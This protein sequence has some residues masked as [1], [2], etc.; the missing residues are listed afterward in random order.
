MTR[1]LNLPPED[2]QLSPLT[3]WTREHW[4]AVADHL[5][6]SLRP[7]FST[8]RARV[9]LPGRTSVYGRDSDGLEGF[10]RSFLLAGFRIRGEDG[11]DPHGFMDWYRQGLVEGTDPQS[12]ERWPR[13]DEI[14][15][16]KVEA[17]SIALILDMT[18]QWLWN[19]LTPQEQSNVVAWL[20]TVIGEDYPRNNW[21]WFQIVV[22]TFLAS[23]DGPF[24]ANDVE[25]GLALHESLA[26]EG[27]WY[28]DGPERAFD[29]Y[30]G[31][32]MHFYPLLW[33]DQSGAEDFGSGRFTETWRQ[34]LETYL[35]DYVHLIGAD[36]MPVLQ[37]RSLIYR[38]AAAAPLWM[39]A[40][41]GAT[42]QDLGMIRRG[43]SG[44]VKAFIERGAPGP[45][46]LLTVGLFDEWPD[47]AQSY[48]G[49]GSPYWAAK[50]MLGLALP[51]DHPAWTAVERPLP[52]ETADFL[53]TMDAPGWLVSGTQ[54]DGIVRISNHGT[55]H[56]HEGSRS[57]ESPSYAR[58]GYSTATIPPLTGQALMRPLD[59]SI[60]VVNDDGELTHRTGFHRN[61]L[62]RSDTCISGVTT[63]TPHWVRVSA[64]PG[65]DYGAGREG[66][67]TDAPAMVTASAVRGPW[68]VRMMRFED[69]TRSATV[70]VSGWPLASSLSSVDQVIEENGAIS[71]VVDGLHSRLVPV[72]GVGDY[73]ASVTRDSHVSPLGAYT[74]VPELVVS[75]VG[76]DAV[77]AVAVGL[78]RDLPTAPTVRLAGD[79]GGN[80]TVI[81]RWGDNAESSFSVHDLLMEV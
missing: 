62:S 2:R 48:S 19:T 6:L 21:V 80:R 79:S 67:S 61:V 68:E 8:G 12:P 78:G 51:A 72:A 7:R 65:P 58:F 71:V 73:R 60:A 3:G 63:S 34:R 11:R 25:K 38:F 81:I 52:V 14:G 4:A 16:A 26:R 50:G 59:S 43:A 64:T 9:L 74:A 1:S 56:A 55:D 75:A 77:L 41:T 23:V 53:R 39:G 40:A 44:I 30:N 17:A 5:L 29:Y 70:A 27:G 57:T 15:Q 42:R 18:R 37:G 54:R 76:G 24:S 45:D 66:S 69:S 20:A 13:P 49:S 46:G 31:W 35:D 47:M 10:A 28:A 33:A 32:A 22:E 36:G